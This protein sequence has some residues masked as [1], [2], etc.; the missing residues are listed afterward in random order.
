[1]DLYQHVPLPGR[2]ITVGVTPLLVEDSFLED[3]EIF[4][5]LHRLR[6]N[7]SGGPTVMLSYHLCQWLQ[8]VTREEDPDNTHWLKVVVIA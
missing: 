7:R 2:S 5:A 4:W 3:K 6:L 1:M 8:E